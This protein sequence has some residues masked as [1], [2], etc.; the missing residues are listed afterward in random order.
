MSEY[1]KRHD[2][3]LKAMT[4]KWAIENDCSIKIQSDFPKSGNEERCS[5]NYTG[6]GNWQ[7]RMRMNCI[8]RRRDLK[9]TILLI[10]ITCQNEANKEVKQWGEKDEEILAAT[11]RAAR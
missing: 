11:L 6:T 10:D 5:R 9:K 2:N 8:A 4:V 7:H 3:T 1:V